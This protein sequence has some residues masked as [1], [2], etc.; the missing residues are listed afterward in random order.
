MTLRTFDNVMYITLHSDTAAIALL[1]GSGA[2]LQDGAAGGAFDEVHGGD[3][4]HQGGR[5]GDPGI[6]GGQVQA[7]RHVV[8]RS[9]LMKLKCSRKSA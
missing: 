5:V 7:F 2:A 9:R 3:G 4:K 8:V 1:D 6:V